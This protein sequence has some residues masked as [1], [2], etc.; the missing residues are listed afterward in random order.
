MSASPDFLILGAGRAGTTWL[1]RVLDSHP[2]IS[3]SVPKEPHYLAEG[4]HGIEYEGPGDALT[5]RAVVRVEAEWR[6]LFACEPGS[7]AGEASVSTLSSP[8]RSIEAIERLCPDA[9]MVVMLR[10]PWERA[11]SA[12]QLMRGQGREMLSFAAALDAEPER[13]NANWNPFWLYRSQSEY[14]RLLRPFVERFGDGVLV[15][16]YEQAVA[17]AEVVVPSMLEHLGVDVVELVDPGRVNSSVEPRLRFVRRAASRAYTSPRIRRLTRDHAPRSLRRALRWATSADPS[18]DDEPYPAG[19]VESFA[20]ELE[21]LGDLLGD[22]R[23]SWCRNEPS[24]V[25]PVVRR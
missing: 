20:D 18:G 8:E 6:A 1:T 23:P 11:R 10:K 22:A 21:A 24:D 14:A 4:A 13:A 9:R 15:V 25:G 5:N 12:H 3:M 19:F 2:Q 17:S 7:V 16:E